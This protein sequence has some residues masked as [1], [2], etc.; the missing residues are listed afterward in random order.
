MSLRRQMLK[1]CLGALLPRRALLVSGTSAS[2]E[3]ALTFDDGPHPDYTPRVLDELRRC[4]LRATFFVVGQRAVQ[5]PK[6]VRRMVD[7][8]H[9]V[10]HHSWLHTEPAETTVQELLTEVDACRDLLQRSLHVEGGLFRPPKGKLT[11]A[12][13]LGLWSR[14]QSIVL[15]N[16]DP[17]DFAMSSTTEAQQWCDSYQPL[18]GDIVLLHDN[19][20]FAAELIGPIAARVRPALQFATIADWL[21][22]RRSPQVGTVPKEVMT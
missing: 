16:V 5:H 15:W 18:A 1:A 9:A 20:P 2:G 21:P 19:R 11:L 10:G 6:L 14:G 22:P 4:N 8:G 7:E 17:R 3:V 12:K 13:T